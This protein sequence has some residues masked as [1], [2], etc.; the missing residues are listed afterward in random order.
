MTHHSLFIYVFQAQVQI[1]ILLS[2]CF[3]PFPEAKSTCIIKRSNDE[4]FSC[5]PNCENWQRRAL[6]RTLMKQDQRDLKICLH[7][8]P[9]ISIFY[10]GGGKTSVKTLQAYISHNKA[11][12]AINSINLGAKGKL[13]FS[14]F[15]K[16]RT[17]CEKHETSDQ[18]EYQWGWKPQ[19]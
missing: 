16:G 7:I 15:Q 12:E 13:L 17:W 8:E 18:G 4:F 3:S 14:S 2:V 6:K 1:L 10:S 9:C 5:I 19:Q 11:N